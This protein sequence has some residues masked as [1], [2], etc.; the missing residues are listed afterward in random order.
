[1]GDEVEI[2]GWLGFTFPG[3]NDKYSDMK[4]HWHHFTGTDW[5]AQFPCTLTKQDESTKKKAIFRII[6]DG[7]YWA[8]G[9][10]K[11][12]GN[13]DYLMFADIDHAH[14]EVSFIK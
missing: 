6:G 8:S 10:D 5:V 2:A 7:K 13:F 1:V 14:P 11:E 3:R 9:V 4:W 12:K